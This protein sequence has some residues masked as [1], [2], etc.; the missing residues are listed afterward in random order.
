MEYL[1][2]DFLNPHGESRQVFLTF[3]V[4]MAEQDRYLRA[5]PGPGRGARAE[6]GG[7][8]ARAGRTSEKEADRETRVRA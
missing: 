3:R 6:A 7:S 5:A 8:G 2:L 1:G 4:P